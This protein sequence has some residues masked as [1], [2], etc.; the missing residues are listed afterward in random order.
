MLKSGYQKDPDFVKKIS[1]PINEY[2]KVHGILYCTF[3]EQVRICMPNTPD[4]IS[5]IKNTLLD[6]I[7]IF[8]RYVGFTKTLY[9]L[10]NNFYWPK[11][12][13]QILEYCKTLGTYFENG[14]SAIGVS[15]C[16]SVSPGY[17]QL[18]PNSLL[19]LPR[20]KLSK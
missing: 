16:Q 13:R 6:K 5:I 14:S 15:R 12:T 19:C 2:S 20:V 18:S 3:N 1:W 8:L 4:C 9:W 10:M 7:H 17:L 11:I